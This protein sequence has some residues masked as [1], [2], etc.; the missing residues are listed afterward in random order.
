MSYQKS[1]AKKAVIILSGGLDSTT[2]MYWVKSKNFD[3][4]A[5]S[6]DYGQKHKKELTIASNHCKKLNIPHRII[7]LDAIKGILGKSSLVGEKDVPEGAYT[8]DNMTSTVVPNRNMILLSIAVAYAIDINASTVFYGAHSGDHA[9]YPDCRPE[10]VEAMRKAAELCHYYPIAI[11][12]P[13]LHK[14]KAEI[15]K[16]GSDLNVDYS[17]TWSCY[18]GGD[19][20]CGV[21]GTCIERAKA[22]SENGLIDPLSNKKI[23]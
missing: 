7:S 12:A 8:E 18:K 9:L 16:L 23:N 6:L 1:D 3:V 15:V 5:L 22:F 13:F 2:L 17:L 21:C 20:P 19:T 4:Y 14:S 11:E 10:F